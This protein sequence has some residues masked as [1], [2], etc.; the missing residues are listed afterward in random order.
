M[1]LEECGLSKHC[2]WM[3]IAYHTIEVTEEE[4]AYITSHLDTE[5]IRGVES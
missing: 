4:V 2:S 3:A 5:I 1:A